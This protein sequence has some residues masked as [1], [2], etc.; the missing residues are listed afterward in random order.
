MVIQSNCRPIRGGLRNAEPTHAKSIEVA[1][2]S[3]LEASS[4]R[5]PRQESLLPVVEGT[6]QQGARVHFV[7]SRYEQADSR[8]GPPEIR[9][10]EKLG[11]GK[12]NGARLLGCHLF[13]ERSRGSP[14]ALFLGRRVG[15]HHPLDAPDSTWT[16]RG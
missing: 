9:L 11:D 7:R 13:E 4:R 5:D 12:P 14:Q 1:E 10:D 6:P 2:R 15:R 8:R 3:E 16:V